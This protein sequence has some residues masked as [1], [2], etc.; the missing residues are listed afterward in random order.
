[1]QACAC[2]EM[3][4]VHKEYICCC[5]MA[6]GL[7]ITTIAFGYNVCEP[8][9]LTPQSISIFI[10]YPICPIFECGIFCVC[11]QCLVYKTC[12]IVASQYKRRRIFTGFASRKS[13]VYTIFEW[14][15][16]ML[17]TTTES[18][19]F[20]HIVYI[21]LPIFLLFK[22]HLMKLS[23]TYWYFTDTDRRTAKTRRFD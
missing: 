6:R 9:P 12:L 18:T 19:Y 14:G 8:S 17:C 16:N 4:I 7:I 1:M 23:F 5:R 2:A 21:L 22:S 15:M 10:V 3:C 11:P 20:A 13:T